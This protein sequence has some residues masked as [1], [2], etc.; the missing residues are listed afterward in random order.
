[1]E[2]TKKDVL[3]LTGDKK[4]IEEITG[5]W[6]IKPAKKTWLAQIDKDHDGAVMF[7]NT[8]TS[9][10]P[11][12]DSVTGLVRT[13][14]TD[15]QARELERE[16]NLTQG[17]LSPY[18]KN[19]WGTHTIN[20]KVYQEGTVL[21]CDR[22]ALDK[23]RFL[24]LKANSKV[25]SSNMEA[26]ENPRCEYVLT[27]QQIEDK[28]ETEKFMTKKTA[29]KEYDMMSLD[30]QMDFLLVYKSNKYKVSKASTPDF[31]VSTMGKVLDADPQ[32][33]LELIKDPTYKDHIFLK[34][35]VTAGYIRQ[36]GP[37]YLTLGGDVLGNTLEQAL[38]NLR[39]PEYNNIKVDLLT[40][41]ES[42][43]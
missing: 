2:S 8:F 23:L 3:G 6:I 30:A 7:S 24:Y 17:T 33:F 18:N 11:E 40:K 37:T 32:G 27:S 14:L 25:A 5:K 19:Y 20:V 4:A 10:C 29:Y 15:I 35:C 13:G 12:L 1:M 36:S 38:S 41:L 42:K 34:K 22:S 28:S 39:S 43:K 16:M 21:D 9:I 31:I 26:L